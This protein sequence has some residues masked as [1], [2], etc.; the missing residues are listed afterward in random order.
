M[1]Q[2]KTQQ[3]AG[4]GDATGATQS[5]KPM[6][7]FLPALG[8]N[9][10]DDLPI[11]QPLKGVVLVHDADYNASIFSGNVKLTPMGPPLPFSPIP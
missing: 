5:T 11:V 1:N 10:T 7:G 2:E 3:N 6:G 4:I 9:L 8:Q